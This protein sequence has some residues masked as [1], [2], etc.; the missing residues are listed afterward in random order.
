MGHRIAVMESGRILQEGTPVE[1][2]RHPNSLAVARFLGDMNLIAGS[3]RSNQSGS[4]HITVPTGE[5]NAHV[6]GGSVYNGPVT[7]GFRPED[8][9][10]MPA[11]GE[12]GLRAQVVSRHYSGEA[13]L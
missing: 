9:V 7:M 12:N 4:H 11:T 5:L 3:A 10:L 8:A 13:Q 6:P 1:L 2:Y